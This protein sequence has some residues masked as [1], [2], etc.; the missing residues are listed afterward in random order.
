MSDSPKVFGTDED[1]EFSFY[2]AG[3]LVYAGSGDDVVYVEP[4][5]AVY[6]EAGND[7]FILG[8]YGNNPGEGVSLDG[9]SGTD[10]VV[11]H[12][13]FTKNAL[14]SFVSTLHFPKF[15][16]AN[17]EVM[18]IGSFAAEAFDLHLDNSSDA[19]YMGPTII[20]A[21]AMDV[22][23]DRASFKLTATGD[24]GLS[25]TG[26]TGVNNI[27]TG[28]GDDYIQLH[29][30]H[31]LMSNQVIDLGGDN[32]II[33]SSGTDNI[34]TVGFGGGNGDNTI[35]AG[36]GD[37]R[38]TTGGGD[39]LLAGGAGDDTLNGGAGD[40]VLRGQ[41]GDDILMAGDGDDFLNG[42]TGNDELYGDGGNDRM[43]G[44]QGDDYLEGGTGDDVLRGDKGNDEIHG[45]EGADT[46][47][48]GRGDDVLFGG[49]GDDTIFGGSGSDSIFGGE[50]DD[51][52]IYDKS[53]KDTYYGGSQSSDTLGV[54]DVLM[55]EGGS[56]NLDSLSSDNV[57]G[58]E[59][60]DITGSGGNT[61]D[62]SGLDADEVAAM[63]DTDS[64]V[65]KGNA[66]DQVKLDAESFVSD[67]TVEINGETFAHYVASPGAS[68]AD[69]DVDL[70]I[71]NNVNVTL[72]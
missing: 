67:G 54:G 9:G 57:Q 62:L 69:A 4:N 56:L 29:G 34:N 59:I 52:L 64:M 1:E 14:D 53:G 7:T 10:T 15:D 31:G 18:K 60:L 66:D 21:S 55:F 16:M 50:G 42:N 32:T 49:S 71:N 20:D 27:M 70:F 37:D 19:G 48:G 6:G 51:T 61:L 35:R 68:G 47:K 43:Y 22:L 40:D 3:S 45:G 46:I 11:I 63:S 8:L 41:S 26:S 13:G 17:I 39:D 2:D 65:I 12:S 38:V 44:G 36:A 23:N 58:V 33:G 24:I 28:Q 72:S 25:I 5:A 30:G